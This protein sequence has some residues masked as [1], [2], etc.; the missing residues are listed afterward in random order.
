MTE[1]R[2]PRRPAPTQRQ[3]KHPRKSGAEQNTTGTVRPPPSPKSVGQLFRGS[4]HTALTPPPRARTRR[5]SQPN[6]QPNR[7]GCAPFLW[8][9][10][11]AR[12]RVHRR[13]SAVTGFLRLAMSSP[14]IGLRSIRRPAERADARGPRTRTTPGIHGA[15][16][17]C[18]CWAQSLNPQVHVDVLYTLDLHFCMMNMQSLKDEL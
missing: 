12:D 4:S 17:R 10:V 6:R 3:P 14:L 9:L 16:V 13:A 8:P 7:T 2:A 1:N 11:H 15:A 5:R 18:R